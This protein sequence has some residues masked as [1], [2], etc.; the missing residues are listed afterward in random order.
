MGGLSLRRSQRLQE[1]PRETR[2]APSTQTSL[3]H[4][5]RNQSSQ[6]GHGAARDSS[7]QD[8]LGP[9]SDTSDHE[10]ENGLFRSDDTDLGSNPNVTTI[11]LEIRKDVKHMNK[12]FDNLDKKV[13]ELKL[14][15]IQLKQQN[16]TLSSQVMDLTTTVIGL[17]TK[18]LETERKNEQLEA[19]SRRENLK[20]YGVDEDQN[21]T[22]EQS[23][24]KVRDYLSN[25][26][27]MNETD[28]KIE[29]AHRLPSKSKP[30][31]IIVKFS[32]FKDKD[33]VL[34]KYRAKRKEREE[35]GDGQNA[36]GD[37]DTEGDNVTRPVRVSEDFP[38]RVTKART[39]LFPF[40]Q[41]CHENEQ[42]AYLRYD[43]LV[44]DGQPYVYD[45]TH[46][47]P[48]PVK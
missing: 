32:Y 18:V 7:R 37:G 5:L 12:K 29:R 45:E 23:E 42:E 15:N 10:S 22:W 6:Q 3:S 38:K 16:A 31:P 13:K 28:I 36:Q 4:W 27:D 41:K 17:E 21:E 2:P 33:A 48:V 14:D 39:N 30:R 47:R 44:V 24:T 26:L 35:A 25:E 19:Q 11:L 34:R 46:G 40:L 8:I 1:K 9:A 43:T 20:F